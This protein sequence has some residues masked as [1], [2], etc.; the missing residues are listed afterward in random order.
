[1]IRLNFIVEQIIDK[2]IIIPPTRKIII[3]I[4]IHLSLLKIIKFTINKIMKKEKF[5]TMFIGLKFFSIIKMNKIIFKF[6]QI[7]LQIIFS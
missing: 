1:M 7:I 5:I 6:K 2:K 3:K 4:I